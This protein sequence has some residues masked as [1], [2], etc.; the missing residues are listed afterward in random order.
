MLLNNILP[1]VVAIV[2]ALP[3]V[4]AY[5]YNEKT[6]LYHIGQVPMEGAKGVHAATWMGECGGSDI[7]PGDWACGLYG[8]DGSLGNV[9]YQCQDRGDGRTFLKRKEVCLWA[10]AGSN[11]GQCS[12]N[13]LRKGKRFYPLV[14]AGKAVCVTAEALN[15]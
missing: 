11:G 13:S 5:D 3:A 8:P 4:T 1:Y 6:H 2:T 10:G 7:P 9:I 14:S 12:R 15:S